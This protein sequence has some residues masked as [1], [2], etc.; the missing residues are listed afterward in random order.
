MT[1]YQPSQ[2]SLV[3]L[4]IWRFL[5]RHPLLQLI[6][7]FYDLTLLSTMPELSDNMIHGTIPNEFSDMPSLQSFAAFRRDKPGPRLTGPLPPF[8]N[9]PQMTLLLLQGNELKGSIPNN[10]L[11]ASKVIESV[12]L[13]L[14]ILTGN[15][16]EPLAAIDGLALDLGGNQITDF[17][18][19]FCIKNTQGCA[20][21]LCPPGSANEH[22]KALNS[23]S[24]C[25]NCTVHDQDVFFGAIACA[26]SQRE[27]LM[28]LYHSLGGKDWHRN[29]FWGS[30][31]SVCDWYGVGC[32]QGQVIS[33]NL[34]ANNLFGIPN[35]SVFYLRHLK[36]LWLYSNPI[37][38]S[39]ENIGSAKKIGRSTTGFDKTPLLERDWGGNISNF[40]RW[41]VHEAP[42]H[43]SRGNS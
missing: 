17:P 38:F 19:A 14:N 26:P 24:P 6:L 42:R 22:G 15:V 32:S 16:P 1:F 25:A 36:T 3:R 29:D 23:S 4:L 21:F 8:D 10:F 30:T 27:I 20:G 31:A 11:S 7:F 12:S 40:L 39:F 5:V 34:R 37:S 33:I 41:S 43:S 9:V 13:S 35:P 18:T 2:A 28:D